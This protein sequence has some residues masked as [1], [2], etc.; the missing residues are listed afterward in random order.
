MSAPGAADRARRLLSLIPW[1]EQNHPSGAD[2]GEVATMYGYPPADLVRDL[3]DVV[4][5]VSADPYQSFLLFEIL[6]TEDRIRVERNDLLGKPMRMDPADL[7]AL[8]AA[9]RA[10]AALLD[11][12]ELGPLERAVAKLAGARGSEAE[13]VQIRLAAGDEP[14]LQVIREGIGTGRCIDIDYYSY[15]RDVETSRV[16]EPHRCLY[17]GFWYLVAHCRLAEAPRVFRLDR[18]RRA[19]LT[20]EVFQPPDDVAEAMDGIPVDG[21]LPE[22]TL[23]LDP[24]VRWVVDQYPHTGLDSEP[25]GRL[26]VTLPVTADRWLER[27]LLRL[28]PAAEVVVA[29][30]GLGTDL[31]AAA[32][33]RVL[34]R[35]R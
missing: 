5:F 28:G 20:D 3:T 22:V 24:G 4:N 15:G 1:L 12:D 31:R 33:R 30:P 14:V 35:Y 2:I 29:P 34:A 16:V 17:D 6:V 19:E 21:S 13:A 26:R 11:V 8:V 23:L 9:G 25:D 18:V 27:L 32:A 10:V 7:A